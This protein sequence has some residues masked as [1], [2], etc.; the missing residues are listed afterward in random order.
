M[1]EHVGPKNY[2]T[3]MEIVNRCLK[4]DGLFL[5]HTIGFEKV[6]AVMDPWIEKYIFPNAY[7]PDVKGITEAM[8][9]LFVLEDWHNFGADYDTTLMAWFNNFDKSWKKLKIHY[10]ERFYRM[11]KYY[12]LECAGIFRSRKVQLWQLVLSKEGVTKG[13]TSVR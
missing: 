8:D 7:I 1:L 11:W 12:L 4:D 10:S 3:Y 5:L 13:Y 6:K 9:G 2:R